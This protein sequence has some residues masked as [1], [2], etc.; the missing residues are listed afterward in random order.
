MV[1]V[2]I[3][4]ENIKASIYL[5]IAI[6]K[7]FFENIEIIKVSK[8]KK[9]KFEDEIWLGIGYEY[10]PES[11]KFDIPDDLNCKYDEKYPEN[12]G[13]VGMIWK[14][15]STY[16]N[17]ISS[18]IY[19]KVIRPIDIYESQGIKIKDGIDLNLLVEYMNESSFE[20]ILEHCD[21]TFDVKLNYYLD[22]YNKS[23][24]EIKYLENIIKEDNKKN[25]YL[26]INEICMDL[27]STIDYLDPGINYGAIIVNVPFH[28]NIII[29][30]RGDLKL[31]NPLIIK[32][33]I[34]NPEDYISTNSSERENKECKVKTFSSALEIIELAFEQKENISNESKLIEIIDKNNLDTQKQISNIQY[35]INNLD[36]KFENNTNN[37]ITTTK[38]I[39]EKIKKTEQNI[40]HLNNLSSDLNSKSSKISNDIN[41]FDKK[42]QN[43]K[44]LF[45][46]SFLT[47]SASILISS[48]LLTYF[49]RKKH[50]K[51]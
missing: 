40:S 14:K 19:H 18:Y 21:K 26:V 44:K 34:K 33:S 17:E 23:S 38:N 12:I 22:K 8:N 43:N 31:P 2:I 3:P 4:E 7:K 29:Y 27:K 20:E 25:K 1:R 30:T 36:K 10:K 5:S 50:N 28:T 6:L 49:I 24:E 51:N 47:T 42:S 9:S 39:Q 46:G 37:L 16:N 13:I 41:K 15:Y 45:W 32:N 35:Q 48:V 11:L